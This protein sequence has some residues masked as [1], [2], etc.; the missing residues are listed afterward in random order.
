MGADNAV[1]FFAHRLQLGPGPARR[2]YARARVEV[3]ERLD[4]SLAV[5]HQGT[6]LAA[7]PAPA[8]APLLRARK[9]RR[10]PEPPTAAPPPGPAAPP[11]PAP[12]R[13]PATHPRRQKRNVD[14]RVPFPD[15][16]TWR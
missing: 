11:P 15:H 16:T 12:P 3:H 8:E 5:Y 10:Y 2:S 1:R 9:L 7:R 13:P 14:T 6:L 4:G